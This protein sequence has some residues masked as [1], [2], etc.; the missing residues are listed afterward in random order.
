MTK[1]SNVFDFDFIVSIYLFL[2]QSIFTLIKTFPQTLDA[3]HRV[4]E[5][6]ILLVFG[7]L[8]DDNN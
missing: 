3:V 7:C 4:F 5:K 2:Y 8:A 6:L 1:R